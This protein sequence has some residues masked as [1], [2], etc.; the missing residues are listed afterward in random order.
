MRL[1][2]PEFMERLTAAGIRCKDMHVEVE[3]SGIFYLHA[4]PGRP[5]RIELF[6]AEARDAEVLRVRRIEEENQRLR[7]QLDQYKQAYG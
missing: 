2:L 4:K 3:F 7:T 6:D 1:K 5:H